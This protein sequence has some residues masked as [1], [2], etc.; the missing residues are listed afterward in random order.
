MTSWGSSRIM[1]IESRI[2]TALWGTHPD[3][4][5]HE[6]RLQRHASADTLPAGATISGSGQATH[7]PCPETFCAKK[8]NN[9]GENQTL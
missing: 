7:A 5:R 8:S 9:P 2:G 3:G 6:P 1:T 4:L